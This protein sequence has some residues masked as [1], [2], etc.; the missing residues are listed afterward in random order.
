MRLVAASA[1][2]LLA[3][4]VF[5]SAQDNPAPPAAEPKRAKEKK[6]CKLE[7]AGSTSRVRKRVCRTVKEWDESRDAAANGSDLQRVRSR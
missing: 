5:A 3:T 1:F 7:E 6:V 4:P 2:I